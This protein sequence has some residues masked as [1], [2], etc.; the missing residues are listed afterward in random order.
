MKVNNNKYQMNILIVVA[1][2]TIYVMELKFQL[3]H[4]NNANIT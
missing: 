4:F 1:K 2:Y 3:P